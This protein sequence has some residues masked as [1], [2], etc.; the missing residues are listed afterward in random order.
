MAN[1]PDEGVTSA[2][3]T[4]IT[5]DDILN[6]LQASF[7]EIYAT[8][9]DVVNF[10]SETPD[11]QLCNILSQLGADTRELAQGV[12]NSFDPNGCSGVVQDVR[13]ALNYL[14]RQGGSFTIQNINVTT[15]KAVDLQ[16]LDGNYNDI[17][18]ASY[19][20][21]D[22]NGN[23]WYLIDS[24]SLPAGTA[25]LPFRSKNYGSFQSTIGSITNQVTKVLGVTSVTNAV[26]PTTLG[27]EEETDAQFRLRR[28]RSTTIKG[29]NNY[30]AM[31]SQLLQLD[32]V[33]DANVFVNNTGSTDSDTGVAAYTVWP[34]VDGGANAEIANIIYQNS[35]GLATTGAVTVNVPAISGQTFTVSF[36]RVT[37]VRLYI[38]FDLKKVDPSI[39]LAENILKEDI[40]DNL[41][42]G[43]GDPAET[44]YITK[45]VSDCLA[46]YGAGVYALNVEVSDDGVTYT[47][48]IAASNLDKRFVVSATDITITSV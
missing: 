16:G 12:Y 24:I 8:D 41:S 32:G 42:F 22:N 13:Y 40:A 38:S 17:N 5:Y 34:I 36:D 1:L 19:T 3:L 30:D 23:L 29:Q 6:Y 18:A 28:N 31:L 4:T 45:V 15:N 33:T 10:G 37:P 25:S 47:D 27:Q 43:L 26:A 9:G 2:G 7:N 14:T 44:S 20:V 21:S 46:S 11:G 35:A 39:N 48:Y